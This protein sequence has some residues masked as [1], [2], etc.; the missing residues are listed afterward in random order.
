V[1]LDIIR[2]EIAEPGTNVPFSAHWMELDEVSEGDDRTWIFYTIKTGEFI[3]SSTL[4]SLALA[5]EDFGFAE[6]AE[7]LK[8][9]ARMA[10]MAAAKKAWEEHR[11]LAEKYPPDVLDN[12]DPDTRAV[13]RAE[14]DRQELYPTHYCR[15]PEEVKLVQAEIRDAPNQY[16]DDH[17]FRFCYAEFGFLADYGWNAERG[18]HC[19]QD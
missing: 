10:Y 6:D 3:S 17:W 4:D 7:Q 8:R 13:I 15:G 1:R 14:I 18:A 9:T 5:A 19:Y 2:G 12:M 11:P 16:G